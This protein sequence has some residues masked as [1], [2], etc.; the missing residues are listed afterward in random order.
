MS[1]RRH[2]PFLVNSRW[3]PILLEYV[4]LLSSCYQLLHGSWPCT[5]LNSAWIS[6]CNMSCCNLVRTVKTTSSCKGCA[7]QLHWLEALNY[8]SWGIRNL[9]LCNQMPPKC[10]TSQPDWHWDWMSE[11]EVLRVYVTLSQMLWCSWDLIKPMRLHNKKGYM[12]LSHSCRATYTL[13]TRKRP[14]PYRASEG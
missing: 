2:T 9:I 1:A 7:L 3:V 5:K 11:N 14:I 12:I 13:V 10:P 8:L 6:T 4:F